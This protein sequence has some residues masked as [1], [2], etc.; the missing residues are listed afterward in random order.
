MEDEGD[1]LEEN[2]IEIIVI[3]NENLENE[4]YNL[5]EGIG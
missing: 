1:F 4:F 3:V 2:Y 5:I